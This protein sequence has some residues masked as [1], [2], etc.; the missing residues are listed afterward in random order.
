M[1]N[2]SFEY[3]WVLVLIILFLVCAKFCKAKSAAIIFP[4]LDIFLQSKSKKTILI[5]ALK[6]ITIILSI[7]AL[8]SPVIKD[9]MQIQKKDGYAI[10]MLLDASGS[11]RYGFGNRY[12]D[13]VSK[14]DISVELADEFVQKREDDQIG[15]VVFGNFAYVASPLTYDNQILREIMGRLKVGMAGANY[16]VINDSLF[17]GTKLLADSKAKTKIAILLTDGQSR[18]D[19]I[20]Y[21]AAFRVIEKHGIKVYTIGIGNEG[22]YN[23][24]YLK[25]LAKESKGAFFSANNKEALKEVYKKIDMMEKSEIQ[26]EHYVKKSY[27]YEIPLFIAFISLLLYTFL[28]NKRSI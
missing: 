20:P 23:K 19:T 28:I 18:G 12:N 9:K 8:A 7:I 13:N 17:Q 1:N 21:D 6:W 22:E 3:P 10:M 11:M 2:L 24:N 5:T 14:F 15:L 25:L 16:T 26:A 4:H 27:Y